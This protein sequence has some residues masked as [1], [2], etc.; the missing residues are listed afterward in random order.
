MRLRLSTCV[1][2][3][4]NYDYERK[5]HRL[6]ARPD[7]EKI[8]GQDRP[9]VRIP[10]ESEVTAVVG[11]NESGKSHLIAAAD[12]ALTGEVIDRGDFCCYSLLFL[13]AQGGLRDPDLGLEVEI[14]EG[15]IEEL[16][17]LPSGLSQGDRIRLSRLGHES[18]LF[19]ES[20]GEELDLDEDQIAALLGRL[21]QPETLETRVGRPETVSYGPCVNPNRGPSGHVLAAQGSLPPLKHSVLNK[22]SSITRPRSSP[23]SRTIRPKIGGR[24]SWPRRNGSQTSL[25]RR[26]NRSAQDRRPRRGYRSGKG[27]QAEALEGQHEPS[28][29]RQLNFARVWRQDADFQLLLNAHEHGLSFTVHHRTGRSYPFDERSTGLR[30][31]LSYYVQ[32]L[33]LERPEKRSVVLL[34]DEPD[35]YLSSDGQQDL[36]QILEEFAR[37]RNGSR[38][39]QVIYVTHSPFLINKNAADRIRVLDKGTNDEGTRSSR[40]GPK[41]RSAPTLSSWRRCCRNRIYRRL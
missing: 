19:L 29:G 23:L 1:S 40:S 2:F 9:F 12:Q 4:F 31:F 13:V 25:R 15:D 16:D 6:S 30:Y 38:Q 20:S 5:A 8:D 22:A 14:D 18:P 17:L 26:P 21:P 3:L 39:D 37:R 34:V 35:A 24:S 41:S 32:L 33:A 10:I 36:L 11:A 28:P 7:W 27:G